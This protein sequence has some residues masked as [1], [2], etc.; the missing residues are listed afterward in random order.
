MPYK[1]I[2][3]DF[4]TGA[5]VD[6]LPKVLMLFFKNKDWMLDDYYQPEIDILINFIKAFVP[7]F[8]I[9][10]NDDTFMGFIYLSHFSGNNENKHSCEISACCV[11][12]FWGKRNREFLKLFTDYLHETEKYIKIIAK[13]HPK[14]RSCIKILEDCGFKKEGWIKGATL[15]NGR[16]SDLLLF[17]KIRKDFL[18]G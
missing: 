9:V 13:T 15:K 3:L 7:N 5:G 18:N 6:Y 17:G 4:E 16:L 2:R 14:N 1:F 10:L 11:P 8:Y 12:E